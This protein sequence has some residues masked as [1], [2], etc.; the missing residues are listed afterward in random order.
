MAVLDDYLTSRNTNR[1]SFLSIS[2]CSS[3]LSP[4]IIWV[5]TKLIQFSGYLL[6]QRCKQLNAHAL[7]RINA[8][9]EVH[10]YKLRDITLLNK[11]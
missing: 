10:C 3:P 1:T 9:N 6:V 4:A 11:P 5:E 2:Y 8:V 7:K